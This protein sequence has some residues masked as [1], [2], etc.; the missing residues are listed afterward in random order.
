MDTSDDAHVAAIESIG[1][2][3]RAVPLFMTDVQATAEMASQAF[4]LAGV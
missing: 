4:D 2:R 3:C 1:I